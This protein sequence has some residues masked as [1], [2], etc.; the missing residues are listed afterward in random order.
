MVVMLPQHDTDVSY[1]LGVTQARATVLH[2]ERLADGR[3]VVLLDSTPCHPVDA[4]W[5]DQGPDRAKL[6]TDGAEIPVLDAVVAASNGSELFLG[7]D[8]PVRKGTEGWS[9][10][11]AHLVNGESAPAEG[12][13]LEVLVDADYRL[14]LSSGH[15]ACHLVSLALNRAVAE[16]WNK[17]V[18]PDSLGAPDFDGSAIASSTI[19][20]YGSTDVYRLNKSLRR[21]G[22]DAEGLEQALPELNAAINQTVA[23]WLASG[24]EIRINREGEGLTDRR[25]WSC[26]LPEGTASI[27]CG[28]THLSSLS[29]LGSVNV[30]LT[31]RESNGPELEM[32]TNCVKTQE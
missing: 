32:T 18:R 22:F 8:I 1:P 28:G 20:E 9:F 4:A 23:Q 13:Q 11:V 6:L 17:E 30:R 31:L 15:S 26:E 21:K 10:L 29:E 25:Y 12:S 5:P 27:P 24:A 14:A 19:T 7:S 16:R 2:T 3:A